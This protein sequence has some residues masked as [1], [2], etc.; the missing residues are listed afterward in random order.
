MESK[1]RALIVPLELRNSDWSK[2]V[3]R[4]YGDVSLSPTFIP[5]LLAPGI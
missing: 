3:E 4:T 1:I 2:F 5:D